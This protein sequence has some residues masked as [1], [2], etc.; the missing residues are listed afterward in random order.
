MIIAVCHIFIGIFAA[1]TN[2]L[3]VV[4]MMSIFMVAYV[5]TNG[6]IIWLYVS[7]IV[8]DAALGFC[9]F[10]LWSFVLLLSL[11]TNFL[12]ESFLRPQGVFW[13]FGAFS[14]GGA[15]FNYQFAKETHGLSDKEKKTL[16]S[17]DYY[18]IQ[19]PKENNLLIF[20]SAGNSN[21]S[22]VS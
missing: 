18:V 16:Y 19:R 17:K 21:E 5:I 6:P 22:V 10:V 7:E 1:T 9:L 20:D 14:L 4:I 8:S 3:A 2:D 13:I 11:S 12:M 15:Y